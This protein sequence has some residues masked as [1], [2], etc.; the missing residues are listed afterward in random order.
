MNEFDKKARTWDLDEEKIIRARTVAGEI[1]KFLIPGQ[2]LNALEFGCGTGLLSIELKN[3]FN[4]IVLADTSQGMIA[5]IKEKISTEN[6][7]H[8]IPL[9]IDNDAE[10]LSGLNFDVVYSLMTFHHIR[11]LDRTLQVLHKIIKPGGL[12]FII[13]LDKEDGSFHN[14]EVFEGHLGFERTSIEE[15][16]RNNGFYPFHYSLFYTIKK[17]AGTSNKEF[18]LFMLVGEKPEG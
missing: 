8:F 13:D 14:Y 11:N 17:K 12:L 5:V 1:R 3:D 18:P 6:L 7:K 10:E 15:Q 2:K 9:Q 4:S 16:L